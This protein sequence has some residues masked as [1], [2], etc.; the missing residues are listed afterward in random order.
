MK[1]LF[2]VQGQQDQGANAAAKAF[3]GYD[4][5]SIAAALDLAG[6]PSEHI[7][8][9]QGWLKGRACV[10]VEGKDPTANAASIPT[11]HAKGF[12]P[13]VSFEL[14]SDTQI[15][16]EG[17]NDLKYHPLHSVTLNA[18]AEHAARY[19]VASVQY[20]PLP[21]TRTNPIVARTATLDRSAGTVRN[22]R[23][24]RG[25]NG[26][27]ARSARQA[28]NQTII[29]VG[30]R[31]LVA[32]SSTQETTA[33]NLDLPLVWKATEGSRIMSPLPRLSDNGM[34]LV[35]VMDKNGKRELFSLDLSAYSAKK[36]V[37][38]KSVANAQSVAELAE[39]K[40]FVCYATGSSKPQAIFADVDSS[41]WPPAATITFE[42]DPRSAH[43]S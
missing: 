32:A 41:Q 16:Y 14:K 15:G 33:G 29:L 18:I 22:I 20:T 19:G 21:G 4:A 8:V 9:R 31:T 6:K 30:K 1:D 5:K 34:M 43:L 12:R 23:K 38:A 26:Y 2:T 7:S 13:F 27:A 40:Q 42:A 17:S 28:G 36:A 35:T 24:A 10:M 39:G 37:T 3:F 11:S 25:N